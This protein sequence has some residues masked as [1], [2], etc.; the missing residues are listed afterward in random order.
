[1]KTTR[2]P[3]HVVSK[4]KKNEVLMQ[5]RTIRSHLPDSMRFS[6]EHLLHML[7]KYKMVYVKPVNGTWGKGVIR[8]EM[9]STSGEG[10][11]QYHLDT[12]V[13]TCSSFDELYAAICKRKF[14]KRYLIQQ[15]IDL[16]QYQNRRFDLRVMVQR[17]SQKGWKTTGIIGRLAHPRKIVTNYHNDGKL[18]PVEKL[19][20][21]HLRESYLPAYLAT[22]ESLGENIAEHLNSRFPGIRD[23]GVDVAL[24]QKLRPWILE[25]NTSPDPYIFRKLK[26]KS[27][28]RTVM[29]YARANGKLKA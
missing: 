24:D 26:D 13:R 8:V 27:M 4:W 14:K 20:A 29:Q 11:Y 12:T 5:H 10:T 19:L 2:H 3:R 7:R 28:F 9:V 6:R 21:P 1:M 15:G 22:L 23:L 16:L 17:T 25:V 18:I